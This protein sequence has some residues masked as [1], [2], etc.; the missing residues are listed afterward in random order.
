[1]RFALKINSLLLASGFILCSLVRYM[2][3]MT[4]DHSVHLPWSCS[5]F[6]ALM[7]EFLKWYR[8]GVCHFLHFFLY[9]KAVWPSQT[10]WSVLVFSI[11][12]FHDSIL[13]TCIPLTTFG[14]KIIYLSGKFSPISVKMM[15]CLPGWLEMVAFYL[16]GNSL[17]KILFS[18]SV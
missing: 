6:K 15:H 1:M 2:L 16:I 7:F 12:S 9:S 5:E 13:F 10:L 14:K 11:K 17:N 4:Y 18:L 8:Y 3:G